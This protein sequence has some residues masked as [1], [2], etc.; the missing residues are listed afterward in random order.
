MFWNKKTKIELDST[1]IEIGREIE[2]G[3]ILLGAVIA[4]HWE[5][6]DN[7]YREAINLVMEKIFKDK[8]LTSQ[9]RLNEAEQILELSKKYR[10]QIDKTT[11]NYVNFILSRLGQFE[12]MLK[13]LLETKSLDKE[14]EWV[15][16]T[17]ELCNIRDS[18]VTAIYDHVDTDE[19]ILSL[20]IKNG[21][22][23][24]R[25]MTEEENNYFAHKCATY[26][27]KRKVAYENEKKIEPNRSNIAQDIFGKLDSYIKDGSYYRLLNEI[28]N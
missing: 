17:K 25:V 20:V 24:D 14:E 26:N 23:S 27:A 3:L 6:V 1:M 18:E 8:T 12:E 10:N 2:R 7:A 16:L 22:A 4:N 15:K 19:F 9:E 5:T 28:K 11:S 13:P 21:E